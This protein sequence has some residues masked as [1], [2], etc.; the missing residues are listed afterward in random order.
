MSAKLS[1]V[2]SDKIQGPRSRDPE[3]QGSVDPGHDHSNVRIQ[4]SRSYQDTEVGTDQQFSKQ[5]S[6][7]AF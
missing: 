6:E 3:I 7:L 5:T 4:R 2:Q 1:S